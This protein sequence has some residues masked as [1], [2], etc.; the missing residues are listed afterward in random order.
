MSEQGRILEER[1]NPVFRHSAGRLGSHYITALRTQGRLVGWRT[2]VPSRVSVPPRDVGA[3]GE[4]VELG[5]GAELLAFAPSEWTAGSGEPV[6]EDFTLGRVLIDG[7]RKPVFALLR[8]NGVQGRR[9]L[10]LSARFADG[11]SAGTGVDL[12][13]EPADIGRAA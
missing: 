6:L 2:E 13:F 3:E 8:L 7:A 1:W 9:G 12:W 5:P 11:Q 4:W 10:R